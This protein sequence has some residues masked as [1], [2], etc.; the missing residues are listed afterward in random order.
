MPNAEYWSPG[1]RASSAFMLRDGCLANG[2]EVVGARQSSTPTT[3]RELKEARLEL[4][5]RDP[6]FSF[7]QA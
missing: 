1:P 4:L 2:R 6:K 7:C 3:I 5:K